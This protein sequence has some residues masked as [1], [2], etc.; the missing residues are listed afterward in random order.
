LTAS[1]LLAPSEIAR[2]RAEILAWM[3]SKGAAAPD[4][5]WRALL[6]VVR[7]YRPV[8]R[9]GYVHNGVTLHEVLE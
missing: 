1:A 4:C 2:Y 7:H 6:D 5:Q 8:Y 3:D 9:D